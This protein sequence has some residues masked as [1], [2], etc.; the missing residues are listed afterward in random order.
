[1]KGS[2]QSFVEVAV[3]STTNNLKFERFPCLSLKVNWL[4]PCKGSQV[5]ESLSLL[6]LVLQF[7]QVVE[8]V[9]TKMNSR[10]RNVETV[11]MEQIG[12]VSKICEILLVPVGICSWWA[13]ISKQAK[14]W[15]STAILLVLVLKSE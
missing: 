13:Q 14:R 6:V 8:V 1:M 3:V 5:F 9:R 11:F 7:W 4:L 2:P 10:S 12:L 15:A